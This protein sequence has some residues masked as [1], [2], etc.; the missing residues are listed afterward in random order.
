MF[1]TA[2]VILAASS[3]YC[4]YL[5]PYVKVRL[6]SVNWLFG[7]HLSVMISPLRA[8]LNPNQLTNVLNS[9][10]CSGLVSDSYIV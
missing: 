6:T 9:L 5:D 3:L 8:N 2:R 1:D 7:P 10:S 4:R